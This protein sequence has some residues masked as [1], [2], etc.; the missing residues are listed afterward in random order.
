MRDGPS[1]PQMLLWV[2]PSVSSQLLGMVP[3]CCLNPNTRNEV[4]L[5]LC[6]LPKYFVVSFNPSS[7]T[8]SSHFAE[9]V[10]VKVFT[11]SP[12][13][14]CMD[15]TLSQDEVIDP[16]YSW[17]GP[18]GRNLEG[19]ELS[20]AHT[21]FLLFSHC[22]SRCF[23]AQVW[24]RP[25]GGGWESGKLGQETHTP[26]LA[27]GK[28]EHKWLG[29]GCC[30]QNHIFL[31]PIDAALYSGA[32]ASHSPWVCPPNSGL[33]IRFLSLSEMLGMKGN[34]APS[35]SSPIQPISD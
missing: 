24:K 17:T 35:P 26:L 19:E 25:L 6:A 10:Y 21:A 12:T 18:D 7:L 4:G 23:H 34:I 3:F 8:S 32:E 5:L 16:R 13:L 33:E 22:L 2:R 15:L 31:L 14:V 9:N 1:V 30:T 29:G 28:A 11:N 27:R 20:A